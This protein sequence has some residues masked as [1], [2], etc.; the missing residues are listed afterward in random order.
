VNTT[1]PVKQDFEIVQGATFRLSFEWKPEGIIPVLTGC[2]ARMQIRS[3]IISKDVLLELTTENGRI[4]L[5]EPVGS[6]TLNITAPD[7][8][9]ITWTNGIYDLELEFSEDSGAYVEKLLRGNVYVRRE[10]TQ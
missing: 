2:I 9:A 5:N 7:T 6:I 10:V 3:S 8:S 4:I 1:L